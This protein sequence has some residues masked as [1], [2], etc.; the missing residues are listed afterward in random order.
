[1]ATS[2]KLDV[3]M[4]ERLCM[5]QVKK[6]GRELWYWLMHAVENGATN[7]RVIGLRHQCE[8]DF[9]ELFMKE[10]LY[11]EEQRSW[12]RSEMKGQID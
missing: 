8:A 2:P 4:F 5:T 7:L 10:K 9:I 1:M 12:Q 11:N 6:D 3:Y